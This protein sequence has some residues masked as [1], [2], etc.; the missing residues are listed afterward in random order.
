MW[1]AILQMILLLCSF[2]NK[3]STFFLD[4]HQI[5]LEECRESPIYITNDVFRRSRSISRGGCRLVEINIAFIIK[6]LI[7]C[8]NAREDR[9]MLM[10]QNISAEIDRK[11]WRLL[12]GPG[13][14]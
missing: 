9:V 4:I 12:D 5:D 14:Q 3:C 2:F 8:E 1:A 7:A 10:S 11:I 13:G 6:Y